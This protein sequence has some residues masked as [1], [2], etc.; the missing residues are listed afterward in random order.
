[1]VYEAAVVLRENIRTQA[2]GST[3]VSWAKAPP[4]LFPVTSFIFINYLNWGQPRVR[5][6]PFN[7]GSSSRTNIYIYIFFFSVT[8]SCDSDTFLLVSSFPV[9][10]S[11]AA[12][13][14]QV[15]SVRPWSGFGLRCISEAERR[16][17]PGGWFQPPLLFYFFPFFN[18]VPLMSIFFHCFSSAVAFSNYSRTFFYNN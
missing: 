10:S 2:K 4:P 14:L 8:P 13:K 11:E 12:K 15:Q 6:C 3:P 9:G 5:T 1:M 16:G 7:G 18:R 17:G